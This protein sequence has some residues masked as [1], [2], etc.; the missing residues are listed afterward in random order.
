MSH[1]SGKIYHSIGDFYKWLHFKNHLPRRA[2]RTQIKI[3][4]E[5]INQIVFD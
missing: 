1:M 3:E 5:R 4:S 2:Q